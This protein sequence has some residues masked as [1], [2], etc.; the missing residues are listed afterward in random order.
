MCMNKERLTIQFSRAVTIKQPAT[1][2]KKRKNERERLLCRIIVTIRDQFEFFILFFLLL[3][4]V[5]LFKVRDGKS[6]I[7]VCRFYFIFLVRSITTR[8]INRT[9]EHGRESLLQSSQRLDCF[10]FFFF[11]LAQCCVWILFALF[12][13]PSN[14]H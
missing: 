12:V 10:F 5:L 11:L 1:Q 9:S 14:S 4:L 2:K 6:R 7:K 8:K 13:S 3:F